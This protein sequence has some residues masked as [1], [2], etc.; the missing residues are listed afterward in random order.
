MAAPFLTV[1]QLADLARTQGSAAANAALERQVAMERRRVRRILDRRLVERAVRLG[2]LDVLDCSSNRDR[3]MLEMRFCYVN[4]KPRATRAV[5]AS[6]LGL[7]RERVRQIENRALKRIRSAATD[8][9]SQEVG[10]GVAR[11]PR[12]DDA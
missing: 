12:A 6:R 9:S 3:M 5:L 2:L 7:S 11:C 1:E 10:F 4:G 8:W